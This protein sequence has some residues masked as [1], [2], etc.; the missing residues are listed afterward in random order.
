[1]K[2]PRLKPRKAE[3][4]K[5]TF[6][7]VLIVGG[8][9][10]MTGA[11]VLAGTAAARSGAGL[12]TIAVPDTCLETVAGFEA[13][14][15]TLPL[16]DDGRGRITEDAGPQLLEISQNATSIGIGPGLSKGAGITN[17]VAELY[18]NYVGPMVVDADALNALAELPGILPDAQGPRILTPHIGEFRRLV[19]QHISPEQC[20]R[21]APDF[22]AKLNVI[23]VLKGNRTLVTDGDRSYENESGNPGMATGGAG[24]VLT[25]VI[26]ALLGQ[27]LS[28][29]ESA[30]LGVHAHG[31]AGDIAR[32]NY[33]EVSLVAENI[34]DAL[35]DVFK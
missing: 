7:R 13:N 31:R 5:G 30:V 1:M 32:K 25:G 15:M 4:Y 16:V 18:T 9:R 12:V 2:I 20:R 21:R 27:D 24:D 35:S 28:P 22:A 34:R 19:N 29:I 8:S 26:S 14:Y 23:L 10:G 17:A 6:G 11:P 3:S 33:G